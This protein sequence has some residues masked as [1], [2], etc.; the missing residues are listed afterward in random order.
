MTRFDLVYLAL[1][2]VLSLV[3]HFV[4]WRGFVRRSAIDPNGA[5]QWLWSGW[6]ATL[7]TL[8]LAGTA[9]WVFEGRA[10]ESL[11]FTA[12]QGW[13]LWAPIGLLLLYL[14]VSARSA[15]KVVQARRTKRVKIANASVALLAPTKGSEL[16][17]WIALSVSAGIG[18]EFVYRGYLIWAFQPLMGVWAAAALSLVVFSVS[19]SYQ[20]MKGVLGVAITGGVLTL[21]VLA[22][23]SLWP[24]IALHAAV[25][26]CHGIIAWLALRELPGQ[27]APA[28]VPA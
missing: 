17:H 14:G 25:D 21:A 3:D 11:R 28:G 1:I 4:F 24:A 27:A 16:L 10:W 8:V 22:F 2:A 23:G 18:E 5:R 19:H 7:W 12:P 9:L 6:I 15:L 13:R 20:G 26:T